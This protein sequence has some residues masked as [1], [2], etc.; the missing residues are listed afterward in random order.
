MF[1]QQLNWLIEDLELC[2]YR[3]F[4]VTMIHDAKGHMRMVVSCL[5]H[6]RTCCV[7]GRLSQHD[8]S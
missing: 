2:S 1:D 3:F 7:H 5:T 8:I 6:V 4:G